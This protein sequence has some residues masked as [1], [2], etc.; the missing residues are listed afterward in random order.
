[1]KSHKEDEKESVLKT[2]CLL[3]A[4]RAFVDEF[5]AKRGQRF[6]IAPQSKMN[7]ASLN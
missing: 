3:C 4:L 1:M 2:L 7:Q 5:S 6:A